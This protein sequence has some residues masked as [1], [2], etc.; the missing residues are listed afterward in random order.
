[1]LQSPMLL[2]PGKHAKLER[3]V[4]WT[5]ERS[6]RNKPQIVFISYYRAQHFYVSSSTE[7]LPLHT[8]GAFYLC[9]P[10]TQL[11]P[12]QTAHLQGVYCQ[13]TARLS[14]TLHLTHITRGVKNS[15]LTVLRK[16]V[17]SFSV[18]VRFSLCT[19]LWVF[20]KL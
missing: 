20:I 17:F 5:L 18:C 10:A 19:L 7:R 2:F 11:T 3:P 15:P 8:L 1:M 13:T 4:L 16:H 12:H 14:L 9:S 6:Q